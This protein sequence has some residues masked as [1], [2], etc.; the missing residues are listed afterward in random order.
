MDYHGL[1]CGL[2]ANHLDRKS[3]QVIL[4]GFSLV[5]LDIKDVVG[6]PGGGLV[7]KVLFLEQCGKLI[8]TSNVPSGRLMN[9]SNVVPDR[10]LINI[11][12][13]KTCILWRLFSQKLAFLTVALYVCG[14]TAYRQNSCRHKV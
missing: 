11:H 13:K 10:V 2:Q 8:K 9:H 5:L 14:G 12:Y 1:I 6:E 7:D 3:V 4:H